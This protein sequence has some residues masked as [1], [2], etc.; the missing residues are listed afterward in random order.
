VTSLYQDI[1]G[2]L[3]THAGMVSGLPADGQRAYEGRLFTS[4]VGIPWARMTLLPYSGRPFSVSAETKD[5]IGDFQVDYFHPAGSGT[6][7]AESLVDAIKEAFSPGVRLVQNGVTVLIQYSER[8]QAIQTADW[9][10]IPVSV[11]W[12]AFTADN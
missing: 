9:L 2:A 8:R 4:T 12:R 6:G 10:Q 1:R 7:E 3:Q 5:H 11:R